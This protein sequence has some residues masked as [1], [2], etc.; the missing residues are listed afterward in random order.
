MTNRAAIFYG[1]APILLMDKTLEKKA[2]K[3][4]CAI[5]RPVRLN[6]K[7]ELYTCIKLE[8]KKIFHFL[9]KF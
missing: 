6:K 8:Q 4:S 1:F 3:R 2:K 5:T 9:F 7:R